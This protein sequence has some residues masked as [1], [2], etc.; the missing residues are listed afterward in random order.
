[1]SLHNDFSALQELSIKK[2][3]KTHEEWLGGVGGLPEGDVT[4]AVGGAEL[5]ALRCEADPVDLGE[6]ARGPHGLDRLVVA[7]LPKLHR[8]VLTS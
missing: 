2:T 1:M 4:V 3:L 8:A 7:P 5:V 6:D